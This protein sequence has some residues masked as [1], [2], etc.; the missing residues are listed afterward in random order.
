MRVAVGNRSPVFSVRLIGDA[1]VSGGQDQNVRIWSLHGECVAT[2]THGANVRGL[3]GDAAGGF[4]ASV[5]GNRGAGNIK[6]LLVWRPP[7]QQQ[8]A[9]SQQAARRRR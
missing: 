7:Q 9:S 2:F 3:A 1:V 8:P 6:K 4:V 5:G